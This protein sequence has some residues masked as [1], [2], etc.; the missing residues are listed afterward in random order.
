MVQTNNNLLKFGRVQVTEYWRL[1]VRNFI[2]HFI[3]RSVSLLHLIVVRISTVV[4]RVYP[5]VPK[6]LAVCMPSSTPL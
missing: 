5:C 6:T 1:V 2:A 3:V 4:L